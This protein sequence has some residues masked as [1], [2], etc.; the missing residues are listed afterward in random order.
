MIPGMTIT[1]LYF[2]HLS[3]WQFTL[4]GSKKITLNHVIDVFPTKGPCLAPNSLGHPMDESSI[5]PSLQAKCFLCWDPQICRVTESLERWGASL[6]ITSK[7]RESYG[8]PKLQEKR[9]I[10]VK[11]QWMIGGH[12]IFE[13]RPSLG[14]A[15]RDSHKRLEE[16][17]PQFV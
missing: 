16:H 11:H 1:D 13:T 2:Q 3:T 17:H 5:G 7:K 15:P 8:I 6:R 14:G 12:M 4:M 9:F 10:F